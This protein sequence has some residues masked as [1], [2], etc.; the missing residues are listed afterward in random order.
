MDAILLFSNFP[1]ATEENPHKIFSYIIDYLRRDSKPLPP[2]YRSEV[3][4][5]GLKLAHLFDITAIKHDP[6]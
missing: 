2:E 4:P 3:L 6:I 5:L 1:G